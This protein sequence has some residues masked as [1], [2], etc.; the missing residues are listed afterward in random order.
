METLTVKRPDVLTSLVSEPNT[1]TQKQTTAPEH[2]VLVIIL[3]EK[4]LNF[5]NFLKPYELDVCGKKMWEWVK[6]ATM[7]YK[8]KTTT[9]TNESDVLSLI[10][11]LLEDQKWTAVFYSD[12]PLLK[13]STFNE[14]MQFVSSRQTNVL[15][16]TR[17][18]VFDTQY[19]KQA[20]SLQATHT[21]YF[22]EEDFM[23]AYDMKQLAFINDVMRGRILDY[24]MKNGVFIKHPQTVFIDADV[25]IEGGT[26]IG[27]NNVLRGRVIIGKN[28]IIDNNNTI[29]NSIIS[30]G[31]IIKNSYI[32]ESRISEYM[33]VGPFEKIEKQ[34]N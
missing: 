16:L 34:S 26:Q 6:L 33:T 15:K 5:K 23:T 19:I 13:K 11:P 24:H 8:H 10:K 22:D 14:I 9:C 2:D 18:F 12:T 7:P 20:T 28:C 3:L 4:N 31:C 29:E 32:S 27:A 1:Q 21:E 30:D 17:G 25:V